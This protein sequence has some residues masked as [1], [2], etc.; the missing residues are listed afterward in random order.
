M[1]EA[2]QDVR[3]KGFVRLQENLCRVRFQ[4]LPKKSDGNR[5]RWHRHPPRRTCEVFAKFSAAERANQPTKPH[6]EESLCHGTFSAT[7]LLP[8][9]GS[10]YRGGRNS[11]I[12][13]IDGLYPDVRERHRRRS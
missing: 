4:W 11:S 6:S 5:F 7:E 1:R 8:K 3:T 2:R 10:F 13:G 12:I 9:T